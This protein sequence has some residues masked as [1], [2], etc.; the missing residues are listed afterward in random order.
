MVALPQE[1]AVRVMPAVKSTSYDTMKKALR[2][3]FDLTRAQRAAK[4]LHLQC[5]GNRLPSV[6]ASEIVALVPESN[7]PD[8]LERQIFLERLPADVQQNMAA[9]ENEKDFMKLAKIADGYVIAARARESGVSCVV[10]VPQSSSDTEFQIHYQPVP[11]IMS[12]SAGGQDSTPCYA[13]GGRGQ[14]STVRKL[15]FY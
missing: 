12:D 3:A 11:Q 14:S 1:V 7:S 6:L 10:K 9:H 15:C 5:L 13:V 8:Y 2:E 4:L